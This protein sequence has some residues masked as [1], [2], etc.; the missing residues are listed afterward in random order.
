[1]TLCYVLTVRLFFTIPLSLSIAVSL[2]IAFP[3]M[4]TAMLTLSFSGMPPIISA[5]IFYS[6]FNCWVP[7]QVQSLSCWF[8]LF[9]LSTFSNAP[10]H[11]FTT[12]FSPFSLTGQWY[13][14]LIN[15]FAW[16]RNQ[17]L[18]SVSHFTF[19]PTRIISFCF[20]TFYLTKW[21]P[22]SNFS[23]DLCI[24]LSVPQFTLLW[25]TLNASWTI[26]RWHLAFGSTVR[27][28][29]VRFLKSLCTYKLCLLWWFIGHLREYNEVLF[30]RLWVLIFQMG[31]FD[32][33]F[34]F[35]WIK[36]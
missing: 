6:S 31:S 36:E 17:V 29:F 12:F 30:C 1:M 23:A 15:C 25:T 22:T 24:L 33:K 2:K 21:F 27:G 11:H 7:L 19:F 13:K 20:T 4:P 35:K 5:K 14:P 9:L 10:A 8:C 16:H 34:R 26:T 32:S 3:W 28:H 18:P